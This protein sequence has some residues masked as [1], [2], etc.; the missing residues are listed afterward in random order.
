MN[1][2]T[3]AAKIIESN[4]DFDSA[5]IRELIVSRVNRCDFAELIEIL[6]PHVSSNDPNGAKFAI[7]LIEGE[8]A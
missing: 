2:N 3:I 8:L 7:R 5:E 1:V 6:E 4:K